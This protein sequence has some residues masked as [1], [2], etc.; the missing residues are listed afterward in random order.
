[1]EIR[2]GL[3]EYLKRQIEFHKNGNKADFYQCLL[4]ITENNT[5]NKHKHVY[6]YVENLERDYNTKTDSA[7]VKLILK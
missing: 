5:I 2:F 7:T 1:M 6:A 3:K 4:E